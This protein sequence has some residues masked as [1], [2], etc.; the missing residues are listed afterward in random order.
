MKKFLLSVVAV[1]ATTTVANAD[2]AAFVVQGN[3]YTGDA[4]QV[5]EIPTGFTC[6]NMPLTCDALMMSEFTDTVSSRSSKVRPYVLTGTLQWYNGTVA[7]LTPANGVTIT[8]ITVTC[9][10]ST[11]D[12][13]ANAISSAFTIDSSNKFKQTCTTPFSSEISIAPAKTTR[14]SIIEIEYTGTPVKMPVI[15]AD[16]KYLLPADKKVTITAEE[17]AKI[18]YT[19]DG[20]EPT[21]ASTPYTSPFS[22]SNNAFVRAIAVTSAGTSFAASKPYIV[23]PAGV[24]ILEYDFTNVDLLSLNDAKGNIKIADSWEADGTGGNK[25][26]CFP[27]AGTMY[28]A[29]G[30]TKFTADKDKGTA[31]PRLYVYAGFGNQTQMRIYPN[32]YASVTVTDDNYYLAGVV[33]VGSINNAFVVYDSD[34]LK[35]FTD[36]NDDDGT[37][38]YETDMLK[39]GTACTSTWFPKEGKKLNTMKVKVFMGTTTATKVT[40]YID[41]L[42]VLIAPK[43]SS[44]IENAVVDNSNAPVEYYNLQGVRVANPTAGGIYVKR[45]GNSATKIL[46]K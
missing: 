35:T 45:Q 21:E 25:R 38:H 2:K 44:G 18:Y 31:L 43:G 11:V 24:E 27:S 37:I 12:T 32:N 10:S 16:H 34:N 19:T 40:Q 20:S 36:T 17:G 9:Q 46:V 5:I 14:C 22:L 7:K 1:A 26:I 3:N 39:C 6:P 33:N 28:Y 23:V 29:T 13:Y 30:Q 4:T 41:Q 15:S 8:K 42:Y